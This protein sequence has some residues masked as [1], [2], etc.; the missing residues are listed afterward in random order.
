MKK[1]LISVI[2]SLVVGLLVGYFL[3]PRTA[4]TP[5]RAVGDTNSTQRIASCVLDMSTTTPTTATTTGVGCLYNGDSK[6]RIVTN[7]EFYLSGLGSM[8]GATGGVASTTWQLGTS[9]NVYTVPAAG[10]QLLNTTIATSSANGA[11]GGRLY[12]SSTTPGNTA[13]FVN[14]VWDTGTNLNL[15]TNATT[16]A[17]SIVG[18]IKVDY[19]LN[20]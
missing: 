5:F 6:D 7:V 15:F 10:S 11:V 9:T 17:N 1:I 12:V 18:T 2:V 13:V 20:N 14:R 19:F 16:G 4:N 8:I 3:A